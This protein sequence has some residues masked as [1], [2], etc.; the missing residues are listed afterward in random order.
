MQ[1]DGAGVFILLF[2]EIDPDMRENRINFSK[3]I[4]FDNL[5]TPYISVL[6][7]VI[8]TVDIRIKSDTSEKHNEPSPSISIDGPLSG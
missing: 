5:H 1:F 2:H 7:L 4:K 3:I 8:S 6:L